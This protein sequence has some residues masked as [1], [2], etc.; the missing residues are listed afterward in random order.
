MW[1]RSSA[2]S[3]QPAFL[4]WRCSFFV[5]RNGEL[6]KYQ[7]D[8]NWPYQVAIA[9]AVTIGKANDVVREFCKDLSLAPR[10][11][12]FRRDDQ[13]FNVWCF[14][15]EADAK[16]FMARFGGELIDLDDRPRWPA[17]GSNRWIDAGL[18]A[19][20][21][22]FRLALISILFAPREV[23][24]SLYSRG[25]GQKVGIFVGLE[26][27]EGDQSVV[28]DMFEYAARD[29][30]SVPEPWRVRAPRLPEGASMPSS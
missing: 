4:G 17:D 28:N 15:E 13:W 14:A 7:L 26:C 19:I 27:G 25:D 6:S 2:A 23:T 10:S 1:G 30:T 22:E 3:L 24:G 29:D 5:L 21:D 11:H 20:V 8:G 9:E 16:K 18:S 12:T